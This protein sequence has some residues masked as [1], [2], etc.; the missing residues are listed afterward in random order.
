MPFSPEDRDRI[1]RL[2]VQMEQVHTDVTEL[3]KDLRAAT[4]EWRKLMSDFRMALVQ[5]GMNFNR[6]LDRMSGGWKTA[7]I[8]GGIIIGVVT[9]ANDISAIIEHFSK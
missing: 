5:Q 4:D 6:P 7:T 9:I 1:T 8:I 2:E 3:K